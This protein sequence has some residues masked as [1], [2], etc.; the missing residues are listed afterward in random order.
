MENQNELTQLFLTDAEWK[1]VWD[2]IHIQKLSVNLCG[3]AGTGKSTFLKALAKFSKKKIIFTAPTGIAA[4]NIRGVTLHSF[5][6]LHFGLLLPNDPRWLNHKLNARKIK[7]I[8]KM[9]LLV[10]DEISMVRADVFDSVDLIL[11]KI[12]KNEL[13]FGG[14]QLLIVGDNFQLEPVVKPDELEKLSML[15]QSPY[16]F[17]SNVFKKSNFEIIELKTVYRQTEQYYINLLDKIR[18]ATAA[19]HDLEELN[20]RLVSK[21][22]IDE[23]QFGILLSTRNAAATAENL[24]QLAKIKNPQFDFKAKI[25]GNFSASN[26]PTDEI[27]SVKKDAQVIMIR[28]DLNKKWVNG[29]LGKVIEI[30]DDEIC[31]LL[32]NNK[33]VTVSREVWEQIEYV[34]DPE[35]KTIIEKVIG[36][37]TQFPLKLAWAITIHKSQG[38]TFNNVVLN[39]E[40][41]AFAAGQLYVALSRC[42]TFEGLK[43]LQTVK[44]S[45]IKV[46]PEV[47]C[48]AGLDKYIE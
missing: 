21:N 22:E 14:K 2:L 34:F 9:D 40:G 16:Y 26:Y 1:K 31:I 23:N 17:S 41:G 5:F 45:D 32:E 11:R 6:G 38:L 4:L 12:L 30:F 20:S 7:I 39:L 13:P 3:K 24:L 43:L 25:D 33:E 19:L 47:M 8:K 46:K 36:T 37:F 10:I 18:T 27:L 15:Y 42:R 35:K 28:N 29:T 48:F 44:I